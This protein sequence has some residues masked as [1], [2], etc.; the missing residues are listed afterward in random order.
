MTTFIELFQSSAGTIVATLLSPI[1]SDFNR[2]NQSSYISTAYLLSVCCFTPLYGERSQATVKGQPSQHAGRLSDILGRK[3]AML[4]ALT[5][6]GDYHRT[7]ARLDILFNTDRLWH[8]NM[9]I[10][11]LHE[12]ADRCAFLSWH[13]WRWVSCLIFF[14]WPRSQF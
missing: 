7:E 5:L 10:G 1:G 9:W 4:L 14:S 2:S 8:N 13:G 11:A 12:F 6:F 3:G